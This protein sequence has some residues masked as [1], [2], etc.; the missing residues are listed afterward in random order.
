MSKPVTPYYFIRDLNRFRHVLGVLM[1][2][3]AGDVLYHIRVWEHTNIG[4][5]WFH[6]GAPKLNHIPVAQRLREA[7]E[8]LGPVYIKMGQL[9]ASRPD[10]LPKE[11]CDE[12]E[13]LED[14]VDFIPAS[15]TRAIVEAELGKPI[16]EIFTWFDD[17]PLAAASLAQ[18]HRA[19]LG[20]KEV[21]VKIQRPNLKKIIDRD[22]EILRVLAELA[23]SYSP[24]IRPYN[25]V[26]LVDEFTANISKELDFLTEAKNMKHFAANFAGYPWV[27]VPKAYDECC[28]SRVLTMEFLDGVNISNSEQ[29]VKGGYDA[30]EIAAHGV[31]IMLKSILEDGFFHAD[32][33]KGNMII[34][35][36]NVVGLID[37]GMMGT[38]STRSRN[39]L[40]RLVYFVLIRDEARLARTLLDLTGTEGAIDPHEI[41]ED[42]TR[43]LH[44][45]NGPDGSIDFGPVLL[46][47]IRVALAHKAPF[48]QHLLWLLKSVAETEAAGTRLKVRVNVLELARPYTSRMISGSLNPRKATRDLHLWASD[49]SAFLSDFPNDVKTALHRF[50]TG[51]TQIMLRHTGLEPAV[52]NLRRM[53]NRMA[54]VLIVC[55]LVLASAILVLSGVPPLVF[56]GIPLIG[57]IGFLVAAPFAIILAISIISEK[58]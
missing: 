50:T 28:T 16:N 57:L 5:P 58:K 36:G 54:L 31:E 1:K 33:H 32:P 15:E 11:L 34:M 26:G 25:P 29:L 2:H 41:E 18:V 17:T 8:E 56:G 13:K 43:V 24:E 45:C 19:T 27:R 46:G 51:Q 52:A 10:T 4:K 40:I 9:L 6:R 44:E 22:L 12:L 21:V 38:L 39:R 35:P 47:L 53:V 37:F 30:K 14:H 3:G 49:W 48:P 55:T 42:V 23:A 7:I 20:D